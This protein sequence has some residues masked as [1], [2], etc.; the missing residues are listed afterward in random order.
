MQNLLTVGFLM[1][2]AALARR[3]SRGTHRRTDAP[4]ADPAQAH[5]LEWSIGSDA[6]MAR[7]LAAG[8]TA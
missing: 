7:P 5:H 3:E 6:P 1:T 4:A 8:V 2:R